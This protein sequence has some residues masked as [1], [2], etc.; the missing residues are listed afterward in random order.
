M[1]STGG[2]AARSGKKRNPDVADPEE[3]SQ[4]ELVGTVGTNESID[5]KLDLLVTTVA[6]LAES[7][8]KLINPDVKVEEAIT[9]DK[10]IAEKIVRMK[11]YLQEFVTKIRHI[12]GSSNKVAD[13]M[14]RVE[15][16]DSPSVNLCYLLNMND[17]KELHLGIRDDLQSSSASMETFESYLSLISTI[18]RLDCENV[19]ILAPVQTRSSFHAERKEE[20]VVGPPH[21]MN[22][23][24]ATARIDEAI[25]EVHNSRSGH[26]G[27]ET[28]WK[29]LNE[30]YP[31]NAV[32]LQTVKEFIR[33]CPIC[34]KDRIKQAESLPPMYRTVKA[35]EHRHVIG[36]DHTKVSPRDNNG[37]GI[38]T[39]IV[40]MFTGRTM[41]FPAANPTAEHTLRC[42]HKYISVNGMIDEIRTD[43]G[44]D[45]TSK[46]VDSL[47]KYLDIKHTIGIVGWHPSNGVERVIQEVK[48]HLRAMVLDENLYDVWSDELTL[49]TVELILNTTPLSERGGYT[50]F[51]LTYGSNDQT[52]QQVEMLNRVEGHGRWTQIVKRFDNILRKVR[53]SSA[54]YQ[55]ELIE[56]RKLPSQRRGDHPKFLEGELVIVIPERAVNTESLMSRHKGPYVVVN[57]RRNDVTLRHING[58]EEDFEENV[59]RLRLWSSREDDEDIRMTNS[60]NR[61]SVIVD[62]LAYK[63][64][65]YRRTDMYFYV[66]FDD[67]STHWQQYQPGRYG[68]NRDVKQLRDYC[69]KLPELKHLCLTDVEARRQIAVLDSMEVTKLKPGDTFYLDLRYQGWF[70]DTDRNAWL[71][72]KEGL[73]YVSNTYVL[74]CAATK[75]EGY[76]RKRICYVCPVL[77]GNAER[78]L[79]NFEVERLA[80]R[81][82]LG[83]ND[84]LITREEARRFDLID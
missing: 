27:A 22:E 43:A 60:D 17:I 77:D 64:D 37:N 48:R 57:Q 25:K 67:G 61:E 50:A 9:R 56:K 32:T 53:A 71:R 35:A 28:T 36:V 33:S 24:Q 76:D 39:V 47:K 12:A 3:A 29:R 74:K 62:V 44:V 41:L 73:D 83:K 80:Y 51:Q 65:I 6:A 18:G 1:A 58:R 11:I 21:A 52:A 79:T 63:G 7:V 5:R 81:R 20:E 26:M 4:A 69:N 38:I 23:G 59:T 84:F 42:L 66:K 31:G 75:Y 30:W 49:S 34:Q 8:N 68:F 2:G 55:N 82:R 13:Y 72:D 19:G 78:I 14:S 16:R 54:E 10:F 70:K 46:A 40:N 15:L 45:F